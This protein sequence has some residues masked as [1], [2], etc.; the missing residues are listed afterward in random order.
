MGGGEEMSNKKL[1][2]YIVNTLE[3]TAEKV[4]EIVTAR[5]DDILDR[6]LKNYFEQN[7]LE[8]AILDRVSQYI[9]GEN[10][11]T[12]EWYSTDKFETVVK[13][14]IRKEVQRIIQEG[15]EVTVKPTLN[16][17]KEEE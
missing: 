5:V 4:L 3:I 13:D 9:R 1:Y 12:A 15:Y 6:K 17:Q 2:N 10:S 11:F 16:V 14:A 7:H 8:R